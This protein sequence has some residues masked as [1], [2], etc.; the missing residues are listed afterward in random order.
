MKQNGT[1]FGLLTA[2]C[3]FIGAIAFAHPV[4]SPDFEGMDME[5]NS[6]ECFSSCELKPQQ[7]VVDSSGW[8]KI[9]MIA[10]M[11][12]VVNLLMQILRLRQLDRWLRERKKI[13]L[14][15]YI[16]IAMGSI[17]GGLTAYQTG[18]GVFQSIIAG[19]VAGVAA[20]GTFETF[21][22]GKKRDK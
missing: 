7:P 13:W 8:G 5:G 12:A 2:V 9:G 10:G 4:S 19:L 20:V 21:K 1:I 14:K 6:G 16:S 11:I 17:L 3:L 15:P 22:R 18:I